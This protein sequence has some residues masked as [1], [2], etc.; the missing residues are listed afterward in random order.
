MM[1]GLYLA[2]KHG[3]ERV[4]N[5]GYSQETVSRNVKRNIRDAFLDVIFVPVA[6]FSG[7]N[8]YILERVFR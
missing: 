7:I 8:S 2:H 6:Y 4:N 5:L 1:K 3:R